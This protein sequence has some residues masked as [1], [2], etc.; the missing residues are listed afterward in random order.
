[1][2]VQIPEACGVIIRVTIRVI[3]INNEIRASDVNEDSEGNSD[4]MNFSSLAEEIN[5]SIL[6]TNEELRQELYETKN[7]NSLYTLELEDKIKEMEENRESQ[8]KYFGVKEEELLKKIE[9]LEKKLKNEKEGTENLI[10]YLEKD[11]VKNNM[12]IPVQSDT[13]ES[14]DIYKDQIKKM[15]DTIRTLE[16]VITVLEKKD[17]ERRIAVENNG[18]K[19]TCLNC[20]P[21]LNKNS[22]K[23]Q[24]FPVSDNWQTVPIRH[25]KQHS[26]R[27]SNK[28]L[29]RSAF[30]SVNPFEVLCGDPL[31]RNWK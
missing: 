7:R 16:T 20:F 1:M 23:Q 27:T 6:H 17:L 26:L 25:Y 18:E 31:I 14:C 29:N 9:S 19:Y 5:E 21:P 24:S 28:D 22:Y 4:V 11:T 2:S 8:M 10:L 15:L 13:C 3:P 12:Q 30:I